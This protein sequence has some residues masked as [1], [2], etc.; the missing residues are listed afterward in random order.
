MQVIIHYPEDTAAKQEFKERTT[1]ITAQ[2]ISNYIDRF[3]SE[4]LQ[5]KIK[6]IDEFIVSIESLLNEKRF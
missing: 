5:K 2:L 4:D 3:S 6:L 1:K